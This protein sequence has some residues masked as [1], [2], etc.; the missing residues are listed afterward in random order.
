MKTSV[1]EKIVSEI[2]NDFNERQLHDSYWFKHSE[3][4]IEWS[5]HQEVYLILHQDK[6]WD[7][8]EP[9]HLYIYLEALDDQDLNDYFIGE[10]K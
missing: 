7:Y 8:A 9:K 10:K 2:E 5:P 1:R 4:Q 3:T 6:T